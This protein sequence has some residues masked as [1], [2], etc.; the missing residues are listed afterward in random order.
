MDRKITGALIAS[1]IVFS[2]LPVSSASAQILQFEEITTSVEEIKYTGS[3]DSDTDTDT[4]AEYSSPSLRVLSYG[5]DR[6]NDV[7]TLSWE[8][9]ECEG[10]YIYAYYDGDWIKVDSIYGADRTT[11]VIF[12]QSVPEDSEDEKEKALKA[13]GGT[14]G[15]RYAVAPYYSNGET[16]RLSPMDEAYYDI[17]DIREEV[18]AT[19]YCKLADIL[20]SARI[21]YFNNS[22]NLYT[23][24]RDEDGNIYSEVKAQKVSEESIKAIEEFSRTHFQPG[25]S[26]V[27]KLIYTINWI[28]KNNH[29]DYS[30]EAKGTGYS[31][32]I[33]NYRLGQCNSY[34]GAV[35]ELLLYMGYGNVILQ[36]MTPSVRNGQHFRAAIY[37][38]GEYYSFEAGNYGKNGDW[39]W[40]LDEGL[41]VSLG[42]YRYEEDK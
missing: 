9:T 30:Y 38:D 10:Y 42:E 4:Q 21:G 11:A 32:N 37:A 24:R 3:T 26:D 33:Y 23:T 8:R 6:Y 28:N 40:F 5:Y 41:E 14:M 29:Y 7:F 1:L 35:A 19:D 20:D 17:D 15:H 36:C 2:Q 34:N 13:Q 39:Y 22:Y 25:W 12:Y 18:G 31:D 16:G 27:D